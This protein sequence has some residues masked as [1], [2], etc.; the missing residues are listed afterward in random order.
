MNP[1]KEYNF[2]CKKCDKSFISINAMKYHLKSRLH[3]D[4]NTDL[5]PCNFPCNICNKN[6]TTQQALSK[7][8]RSKMH[9]KKMNNDE[10]FSLKCKSCEYEGKTKQKLKTH[11]L[12]HH[13]TSEEK[14]ASAN[15]YCG[16]CDKPFFSQQY[17]DRHMVSKYHLSKVKLAEFII[18]K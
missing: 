6:F 4:N 16:V 9:D 2:Y 11:I 15:F 12:M 7:H 8:M 18:K 14:E 1:Q 17:F 5:L 10:I 3:N 13:S